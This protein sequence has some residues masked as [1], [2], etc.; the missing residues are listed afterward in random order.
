MTD[1]KVETEISKGFTLKP[2][3][4]LF[5]ILGIIICSVAILIGTI[6]LF[7]KPSLA[8]GFVFGTILVVFFITPLILLIL[9]YFKKIRKY[10][11]QESEE[12]DF[13]I[14]KP[15]RIIRLEKI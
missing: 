7:A 6:Y 1:S 8:S 2:S 13:A 14:E 10:S 12:K 5:L 11:Y 9:F 4:I 15:K 3:Y